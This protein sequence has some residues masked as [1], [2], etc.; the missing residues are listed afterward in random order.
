MKSLWIE[1][2]S[3]HIYLDNRNNITCRFK[4]F[5]RFKHYKHEIKMR[6]MA[7]TTFATWHYRKYHENAERAQWQKE[8]KWICNCIVIIS[9]CHNFCNI[10]SLQLANKCY[11]WSTNLLWILIYFVPFFVFYSKHQRSKIE[12]TLSHCFSIL[13]WA[14]GICSKL[15]YW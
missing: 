8:I 6:P 5:E 13:Q 11:N 7:T 12:I 4:K 9:C 2:L 14:M 1:K 10:S 3:V 15:I